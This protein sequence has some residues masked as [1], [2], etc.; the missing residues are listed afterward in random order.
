MVVSFDG[1]LGKT[2]RGR[3][4]KGE[5]YLED[6]LDLSSIAPADAGGSCRLE[7]PV[8]TATEL[9]K[10]YIR[11]ERRLREL[12]FGDG[13][14]TIGLVKG[15]ENRLEAK[16]V[17]RRMRDLVEEIVTD[18]ESGTT[19]EAEAHVAD[20]DEELTRRAVRSRESSEVDS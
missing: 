20:L 17:L 18:S 4:G 19:G 6:C 3:V 12:L 16:M 8:T 5:S 9:G 13:M 11:A 2:E 10:A 15:E 7:R 14:F 1:R